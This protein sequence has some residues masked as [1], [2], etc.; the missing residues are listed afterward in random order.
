MREKKRDLKIDLIK[1]SLFFFAF[2]VLYNF[3]VV[4]K[5]TLWTVDRIT[6]TYHLPDYSFGF[7]TKLLP[8]AIYHLFF[9]EVYTKQLNIY[10]TCLMLVF[11]AF[12]AFCLAK[13]VTSRKTVQSKNTLFVLSL[14]FLTG[15]CSFAVF[16]AELGML[17]VYWLFFS[18]LFLG[19]VSNKYLKFAIPVLFVLSILVHFSCVLN[20]LILY[21]LIMFYR[22]LKC[23]DNKERKA[24]VLILFSCIGL[25]A[26]LFI[27]FV[28]NEKNNLVYSMAGF[29]RELQNRHR[30]SKDIYDVYYDYSLYKYYEQGTDSFSR[31]RSHP[32]IHADGFFANL[33]NSVAAQF[34]LN[35]YML[36]SKPTLLV[37][38]GFMIL[39]LLPLFFIVFNFWKTKLRKCSLKAQKLFC[40]CAIVQPFFTLLGGMSSSV[41]GSRWLSHA[42]L[43]CFTLFFYVIYSEEKEFSIEFETNQYTRIV[44]ITVYF[45]I[46]ALTYVNPYQ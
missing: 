8:G 4:N 14:F 39:L 27:Y 29:N 40:I 3:V 35:F 7:T 1:Y 41:D 37:Q 42:F 11:F 30:Y 46:Y 20:C 33:I 44:M 17:D 22:I 6:Y 10:L 32:V 9:K 13:L 24:F 28:M 36:S 38:L 45:V 23:T 19:F 5:C 15:P 26:F 31:A 34:L 2:V 21:C 25:T 16:T 43:I 12:L 18:A